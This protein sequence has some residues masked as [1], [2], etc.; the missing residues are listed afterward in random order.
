MQDPKN[1]SITFGARALDIVVNALGQRPYL[2][3]A[4]VLSDIS[5]QIQQQQKGPLNGGPE[6]LP[7]IPATH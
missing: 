3:V 1:I 4:G 7:E 5:T 6:S 2:E